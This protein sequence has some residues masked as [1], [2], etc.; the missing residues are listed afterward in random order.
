[1]VSNRMGTR[2][3]S[4]ESWR[5]WGKFRWRT[6]KFT[7]FGPKKGQRLASVARSGDNRAPPDVLGGSDDSSGIRQ[8]MVAAF[9]KIGQGD[10]VAGVAV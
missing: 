6:G 9:S 1:M 10:G 5:S 4:V 7:S 8:S 3:V 2:K